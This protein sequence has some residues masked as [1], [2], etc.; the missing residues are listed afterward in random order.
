M[1][2]G[3]SGAIPRAM[4]PRVGLLL[5]LG[6]A[7]GAIGW[8]MVK[9]GLEGGAWAQQRLETGHEV[10]VSPYRLATHLSMAF[11][12]YG[13]LLWTAMDV[14]RPMAVA[15]ADAKATPL[16]SL[17]ALQLLRGSA[18]T[19]TALVAATALSGAF[20]AGND[21][22]NAYNTFP[23][24]DGQWVPDGMWAL[25][26]FY[27]NLAETTATVQFDHRVLA[28]TSVV[29]V[30][31]TAALSLVPAVRSALPAL[32]ARCVGASG[33]L[34]VG[35]AS[36]GVATLLNYVPIGLAASH[37]LGSLALLSVCGVGLHAMRFVPIAARAA[38]KRQGGLEA[39]MM[40]EAKKAASK[41]PL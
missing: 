16:R 35:Q 17:P 1:Y 14:L 37:Q 40:R 11:A 12:T 38:A 9:S 8:W 30:A 41:A 34:V 39:I 3:L 7:Q 24:M 32:A 27:R 10:R 5:G 4:W 36:L 25:T 18:L 29:S 23:K 20:V 33:L 22:G 31:S 21:A 2:F 19:S 26:P 13:L 15:V 6:G 28:M